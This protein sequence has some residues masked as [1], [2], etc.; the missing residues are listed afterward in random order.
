VHNKTIS[1]QPSAFDKRPIVLD[2]PVITKYFP[3]GISKLLQLCYATKCKQHK[4]IN[5]TQHITHVHDCPSPRKLLADYQTGTRSTKRK[6]SN[7][8]NKTIKL[9]QSL[10]WS[11][12]TTLR[13]IKPDDPPSA[14]LDYDYDYDKF[15]PLL[16]NSLFILS[17]CVNSIWH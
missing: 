14:G 17:S 1:L 3:A 4:I 12:T 9:I 2:P 8:I 15:H 10:I 6:I 5:N 16:F 11:P 7:L 13:L